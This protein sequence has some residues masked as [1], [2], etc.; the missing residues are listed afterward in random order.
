MKYYKYEW[1]F[2]VMKKTKKL[3]QVMFRVHENGSVCVRNYH[4]LC[5]Q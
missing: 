1:D 3:D 2:F 4:R 5:G